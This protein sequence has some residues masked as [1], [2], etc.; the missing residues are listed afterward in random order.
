MKSLTGTNERRDID[1]DGQICLK[2][3]RTRPIL[4]P[5]EKFVC[6]LKVIER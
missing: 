5:R 1:H 2:V 6:V 3:E 4:Q